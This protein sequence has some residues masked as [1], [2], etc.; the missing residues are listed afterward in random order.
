MKS[1]IWEE[2][3][4][5]KTIAIHEV[6]LCELTR[7]AGKKAEAEKNKSEIE[8][9]E[10]EERTR[11]AQE[12]AEALALKEAQ[13]KEEREKAYREAYYARWRVIFV[14]DSLLNDWQVGDDTIDEE[15]VYACKQKA[16]NGVET[17]KLLE[18]YDNVKERFIKTFGEASL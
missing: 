7:V 11:K 8:A 12:D 15:L 6:Y 10:E 2:T 9:K 4:E 17:E 14:C 1:M 18:L 5:G 13:E 3:K 16:L